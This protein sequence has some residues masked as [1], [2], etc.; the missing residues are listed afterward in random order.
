ME[1]LEM[2]QFFDQELQKI[3]RLGSDRDRPPSGQPS[4]H[5]DTDDDDDVDENVETRRSVDPPTTASRP[6][7]ASEE[8]AKLLASAKLELR[9]SLKRPHDRFPLSSLTEN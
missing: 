8:L 6:T 1:V 2:K 5:Q 7:S 4:P 3:L 9:D